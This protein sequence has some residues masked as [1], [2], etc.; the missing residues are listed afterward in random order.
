MAAAGRSAPRHR[1][2]DTSVEDRLAQEKKEAEEKAKAAEREAEERERIRRERLEGEKAQTT[3]TYL[4]G[5]R[6]PLKRGITS[7]RF[8]LPDTSDAQSCP[9]NGCSG[10]HLTDD[11]ID[12]FLPEDDVDEI[13]PASEGW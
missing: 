3:G 4:Q 2:I 7:F 6:R 11:P 9:S 13:E 1:Q 12:E 10:Y 5:R 8:V